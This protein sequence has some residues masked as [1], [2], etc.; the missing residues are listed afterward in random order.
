MLKIL[1]TDLM[2][3]QWM[4]GVFIKVEVKAN[5]F[6]KIKEKGKRGLPEGM[7]HCQTGKKNLGLSKLLR[8]TFG[9]VK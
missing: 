7:H 5:T 4:G 9:I 8:N 6:I 3:K 2:E 1:L